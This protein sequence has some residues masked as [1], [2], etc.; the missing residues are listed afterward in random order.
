[1]RLAW[2]INRLRSMEPAEVAH[3]LREKCRKLA[4]RGRHEGWARYPAP[5]LKAV[6]PQWRAKVLG[7]SEAQRQAIEAAAFGT[8]AGRFVALGRDW[9]TR[10][11]TAL[12][13]VEF[14]RLDPVT[15]TLWPGA[16]RY[17]F[18]IDFRHQAERGDVKYVWETN[19]LQFL[20]ALAGD[21][22]LNGDARALTAIEA[23]IDSW[24]ANNPPFR[25]LAWASGIEVALRA[26]SL[27]VCHDLAGEWLSDTTRRQ[28]GEILEASAFWLPRF[29]SRFSSAN[30]HLVAEL[31]GEYLI[32]AA[33]GAKPE[34]ARAALIAEI[35][36]QIFAD[37]SPAEQ[38]PT[39]GAFTAELGLLAAA[40]GRQAGAPFPTN[41]ETKLAVFADFI[42]ALGPKIPALGDDDEGRALTLGAAFD[43]DYPGSVAAAICGFLGRPGK[44]AAP[45]DFRT[46]C[47][48][49]PN[50]SPPDTTGLRVFPQGGLSV[51]HGVIGERTADLIFDHGPLGYLSIAAHGHADALALTLSLDGQPVLVDPG[52]WLYGSGGPWRNWFRSTPAHNT[53]NIEDASQSVMSGNFNWSHKAVT[54]LDE[55]T[56]AP[57][58]RLRAH[59]DGYLKCFGVTHQRTLAVEEDALVITDRLLG[60]SR[61]AE[62]VFQLAP[63]LTTHS[64][65]NTAEIRRAGKVLM[66]IV[67]P[68]GAVSGKSAGDAPGA[69]GWVS[70]HF[71]VKVPALRLS[72]RGD[73]GEAGV[74]TRLIPQRPI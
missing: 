13:P 14:W 17:S 5:A 56:A 19:R 25:G 54:T 22:L 64:H 16:E 1:M 21:L 15:G 40:A 52:T 66:E 9:P 65:G 62:I 49:A 60:A 28:I 46:L 59:H 48:G 55:H 70:P 68:V 20:P 31:A 72:W 26:I 33:L 32:G 45:E 38:T 36:K 12:F 29:P 4:S 6:F 69:G 30:N 74:I 34:K 8:L 44:A 50:G 47:F 2:T 57:A 18:D 3:R 73:V 37:G 42:G 41:F 61:L 58:L 51:W 11:S 43:P 10:D 39:Y 71:G 24:H 7:A 23:A 27:I 35:D 53:L 63:G 67:F